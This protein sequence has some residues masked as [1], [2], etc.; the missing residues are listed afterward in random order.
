MHSRYES[1]ATPSPSEI[2]GLKVNL[3][4]R[5]NLASIDVGHYMTITGFRPDG[6]KLVYSG[7][8]EDLLVYRAG[9]SRSSGSRPRV[10]G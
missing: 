5:S 3:A 4:I 2:L 1:G 8:H 7:L 6:D 10:S 9:A